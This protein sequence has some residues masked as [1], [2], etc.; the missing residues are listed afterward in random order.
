MGASPARARATARSALS[1]VGRRRR[2]QIRQEHRG[3]GVPEARG[4]ER[5]LALRARCVV[6][7]STHPAPGRDASAHSPDAARRD[8]FFERGIAS[9]FAAIV[10]TSWSTSGCCGPTAQSRSRSASASS[11]REYRSGW[12]THAPARRI[13]HHQQVQHRRRAM[14]PQGHLQASS[15]SNM[16]RIAGS[17]HRPGAA[18]RAHD[19]GDVVQVDTS[20]CAGSATPSRAGC[21]AR[22]RPPARAGTSPASTAALIA[23]NAAASSADCSGAAPLP[24]LMACTAAAPAVGS[25]FVTACIERV[26]VDEAPEAS[27]SITRRGRRDRAVTGEAGEPRNRRRAPAARYA[28]SSRR[29]R[30]RQ[31]PGLERRQLHLVEP[32]AS[33][34]DRD[35][36]CRCASRPR[37]A[38]GSA[39][40]FASIPPARRPRTYTAPRRPT[41]H[42]RRTIAC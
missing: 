18:R 17:P 3:V 29:R 6:A 19:G 5:R 24:A 13:V 41:S 25:S 42:P 20:C 39:R 36:P 33:H 34:V 8:D 32:R 9:I 30:R 26:G 10:R 14:G 12:R 38:P 21:A 23:T 15:F 7:R 16:T 11:T 27:Y 40:R 28:T 31:S 22:A 35:R 1:L 2:R 37:F 4:D